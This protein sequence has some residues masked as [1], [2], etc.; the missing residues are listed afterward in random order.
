MNRSGFGSGTLMV[1][2]WRSV[3][4]ASSP[5]RLPV[6]GEQG[7]WGGRGVGVYWVV[8]LC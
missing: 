1:A 5:L 8:I 2:E 3:T 4:P 6:D 7:G